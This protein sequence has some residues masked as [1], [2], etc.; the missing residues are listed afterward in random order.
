MNPD[1]TGANRPASDGLDEAT[2]VAGRA[3]AGAAA[4]PAYGTEAIRFIGGYAIVRKLGEGGM[5]AVFLAEDTKLARKAA[6]KTMRPELAADANLRRRFEREARAA[7]AVEHENIVPIWGIGEAAD[8]SPFIAM[9]FLQ[10]ESLADRLKRQP[11][12]GLGLLLKVAREAADGLSAAHAKG[13]IHRDIKP[14]NIWLDGDL[15]ATEAGQQVRRVKLLDFGLARSVSTE[16]HQLTKSGVILGTPAFMAPEQ[17]MGEEIDHRV[18]LFALGVVLF[19]MATG[20][21][22][23]TGDT[24]VSVMIALTTETP[25]PVWSLNPNLPPALS[26]L[27]DKLLSKSA[28]D[29]PATAAEV[30][31]TARRIARDVHARPVGATPVPVVRS[32]AVPVPAA[33]APAPPPTPAPASNPATEPQ[34]RHATQPITPAPKPKPKGDKPQPAPEP[35]RAEAVEQPSEARKRAPKPKKGRK[36][37]TAGTRWAVRGGIAAALAVV[38]LV[39]VL[40]GR[41]EGTFEVRAADSAT[42]ARLKGARVLLLSDGKERYTLGPGDLT[43][44]VATG[45]YAVRLEGAP[46]VTLDAT[47]VTFK[48]GETV[49]VRAT[50]APAVTKKPEPP[51]APADAGPPKPYAHFKFDGTDKNT[52]IG[53]TST[54][55]KNTEFQ[56]NALVVSGK[57]ALGATETPDVQIGTPNVSYGAF[58]VAVRFSA[59][60]FAP[61]PVPILVGGI[62]WRW[63]A[64]SRS[65]AGT[66]TVAL[67]NADLQFAA[68]SAPLAARRWTVVACSVSVKDKKVI[69]FVDGAKVGE[70]DLPADFAFRVATSAQR[71][72]DKVWTTVNCANGSAFKGRIDELLVYDTA[73]TA[74][75]LAKVPLKPEPLS[76]PKENLPAERRAADYLSRNG[77]TIRLGTPGG[78]VEL[79]PGAP[80]PPGPIRLLGFTARGDAGATDEGLAA[81]AGCSHV[82]HL[83]LQGAK[84]GTAGLAHLRGIATLEFL[85]ITPNFDDAGV[86]LFDNCADLAAF[87]AGGTKITDAGV[88]RLRGRQK[89]RDVRLSETE[90]TDAGLAHLKECPA[91]EVLYVPNT[92]VTRAGVEDFARAKPKCRIEWSGGT[93]EPTAK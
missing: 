80:L 38:A 90:L 42:E 11:V 9:P 86:A 52:G 19:R 2:V 1:L 89:L 36:A 25:P 63:F 22:P 81:L 51:V 82:R 3:P 71:D 37:K 12:S 47:E 91:L 60:E 50:V 69:A 57:Y 88:A 28:D 15:S 32:G 17:A 44:K 21:M 48:R 56:D 46:D 85:A 31:A 73:L 16:D 10:G 64:L 6:I 39:F 45:Q 26:E 54:V 41:G 58:S 87:W 4:S 93:I 79:P 78:E 29:R 43:G 34:L 30:S 67:N 70:F 23:F 33:R 84:L 76:A 8:G 59:D 62:S 24:A 20:R 13:L 92:K 77:V 14:G 49:T 27:I 68:P 75:Q 18:D 66:L 74:E 53:E 61:T 55:L 72:A 83:D 40:R 7:A 35:A 5:G 65:A